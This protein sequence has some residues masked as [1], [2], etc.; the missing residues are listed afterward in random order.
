[1]STDPYLGRQESGMKGV[2]SLRGLDLD[3]GRQWPLRSLLSS[4]HEGAVSP[5]ELSCN[6]DQSRDSRLTETPLPLKKSLAS[7]VVNTCFH[8]SPQKYWSKPWTTGASQYLMLGDK[9][10]QGALGGREEKR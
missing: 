4:Q 7:K 10:R 9:T 1:M 5:L 2:R 8:P 3:S 6:S